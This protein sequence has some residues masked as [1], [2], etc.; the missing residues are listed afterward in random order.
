VSLLDLVLLAAIGMAVLIAARLLADWIG[1][2]PR[3]SG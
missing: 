2:F 1:C 3:S